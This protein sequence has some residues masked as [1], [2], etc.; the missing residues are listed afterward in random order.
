MRSKP[1]PQS[2][3]LRAWLAT[4]QHTLHD[5]VDVGVEVAPA[6]QGGVPPAGQVTVGVV[7]LDCGSKGGEVAAPAPA[8]APPLPEKMCR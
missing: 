2:F 7:R 3:Q 5:R 1:P 6:P 8:P 4:L